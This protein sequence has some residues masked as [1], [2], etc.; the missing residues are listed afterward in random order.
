MAEITVAAV[1]LDIQFA[2][3]AAN[4]ERILDFASQAADRGAQ[5]VVFPECALSGY[6]FDTLPEARESSEPVPGPATGALA[7]LC[8]QKGVYVVFGMLEAAGECV[9]NSAVLCGPTGVIGV[10][11]KTHLPFLGVD[12]LA[13]LGPGPYEVFDTPIGRLAML[14]CYD[15]RFP[16]ASRC[17]TLL[18]ADILILPTNWPVGAEA[19]PD[20]TAP[21][22]AVENRIFVVAVNRAGVEKGVSFI[23][24]SQIVEPSGKRL[25]MAQTI[26]EEMIFA[27]FDP[28]RARQKRLVISPGVFEIDTV[29]DRRPELYGKLT[30]DN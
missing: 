2:D 11:R 4:R 24:K 1:Q 21:A 8:R 14:I 12:R 22:R 19:S 17:L 5:L 18:G 10:Y 9:Y 28:T 25:A 29:G 3:T 13:T 6:V 7:K 16:E 30:K 15:L 27:S 20:Y 23:G 26:D